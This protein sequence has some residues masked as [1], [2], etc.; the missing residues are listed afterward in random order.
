LEKDEENKIDNEG[1]EVEIKI[2]ED[3]NEKM[4]EIKNDN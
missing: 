1:K 2:E 4:D 3:T